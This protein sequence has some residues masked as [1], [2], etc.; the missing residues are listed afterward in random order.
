MRIFSA[1]LFAIL[2]FNINLYSQTP[3]NN[4]EQIQ[5]E[6]KLTAKFSDR[7]TFS[8]SGLQRNFFQDFRIHHTFFPI[9]H[10]QLALNDKWGIAQGFTYVFH[11]FPEGE[12]I[13]I[14]YRWSEYRP[15]QSIHWKKK[16]DDNMLKWRFMIEERWLQNDNAARTKAIN[17]YRFSLR[18]RSKWALTLLMKKF[19]NATLHFTGDAEVFFSSITSRAFFFDQ[20]RFS[21]SCK[22][23]LADKTS[24]SVGY[25]H[26]FQQDS[27]YYISRDIM[28]VLLAHTFDFRKD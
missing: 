26:W 20:T 4:G 2:L 10:A 27:N 3:R 7:F 13:P 16:I 18:Y 23:T 24:L 6:I 17:D 5:S 21:A 25:M 12:N 11:S 1:I 22:Y 15:H 19:D 14:N 8:L 28:T 9:V